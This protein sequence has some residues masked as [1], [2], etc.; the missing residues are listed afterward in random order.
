LELPVAFEKE[1]LRLVNEGIDDEGPVERDA[2]SDM[3]IGQHLVASEIESVE[4]RAFVSQVDPLGAVIESKGACK[5]IG[6]FQVSTQEGEE[7]VFFNTSLEVPRLV[8]S[9]EHL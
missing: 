2:R 7:N 3:D 1:Q 4:C 6:Q 8:G 5:G 9:S